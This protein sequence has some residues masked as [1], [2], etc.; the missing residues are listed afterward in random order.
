[1]RLFIIAIVS[2]FLVPSS[3]A[4]SGQITV[5]DS[6]KTLRHY[7]ANCSP[8]V[9]TFYLPEYVPALKRPL[10]SGQVSSF[11]DGVKVEC[12]SLLA[13]ESPVPEVT[14]PEIAALYR[15]HGFNKAVQRNLNNFSRY[16]RSFS[17]RL[18]RSGRFLN[19]I[20]GIITEEG[21]P[22]E[23]V[24]LP[25]IESAFKTDAYSH[26]HASGLWQ[27]MPLTA[28]K[29]G[30]KVDWWIDERR[31]PV[32]STKAAAKY[33]K[34]LYQ[35]FDSWNLVL[36]AYNAGESRIRSAVRK[37]GSDDFWDLRESRFIARETKN[38]VPSYVAAAAIA[39]APE[40][41]GIENLAYHDPLEY[42]E[43]VIE[44]PMSLDVIARLTGVTGRV[45]KGLN[46]ELKRWCTPPD[47]S[48]Y[49]LRIPAGT[50]EMFIA[51]LEHTRVAEL[52]NL[53]FYEVQRGDTVAKIA[54]RIGASVQKIIHMN[55][56]GREAMIFAGKSIVIPHNDNFKL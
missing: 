46:P 41:F 49:T 32:K 42:D 33:L 48:E 13:D 56:L 27:L 36:A 23:L 35:K 29:F 7:P 47:V 9:H 15:K 16:K 37:A 17:R 11:K 30:L 8:V 19:V 38:Y 44:S 45:I 28:K 26:K 14:T 54:E 22:R 10:F 24:Y 55:G 39:M 34:Y 43:V 6:I 31:D 2:L 53:K 12:E 4:G 51:G 50:T 18:V 1:M 20:S 5:R 3:F 21:L 52:M 25:L 40:E